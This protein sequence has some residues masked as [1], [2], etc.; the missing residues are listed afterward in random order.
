VIPADHKWV[1]R[2]LVA[3]IVTSAISSLDLRYPNVSDEV[4]ARLEKA[5]HELER[6]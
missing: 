3:D 6:E 1:A 4:S 5:R 2:T